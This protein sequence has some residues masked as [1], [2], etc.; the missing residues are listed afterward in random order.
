MLK[1]CSTLGCLHLYIERVLQHSQHCTVVTDSTVHSQVF[2]SQCTAR[3]NFTELNRDTA[4]S[5]A[6]EAEALS[7]VEA[8]AFVSRPREMASLFRTLA[9]SNA[10][11]SAPCPSIPPLPYRLHTLG[12]IF[13]LYCMAIKGE[14]KQSYKYS[15]IGRNNLLRPG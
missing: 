7:R 4:A 6:V 2:Q 14:R 9:S 1:G 8:V 5:E 12:T 3:Q 15:L 11:N 10:V 13:T